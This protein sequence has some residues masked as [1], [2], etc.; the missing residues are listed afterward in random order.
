MLT[1][2][3]FAMENKY[4]AIRSD[5]LYASQQIHRHA[6]MCVPLVV[7]HK[8]RQDRSLYILSFIPH[9]LPIG[10]HLSFSKVFST[11]SPPF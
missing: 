7:T 3:A 9:A 6:C 10:I 11:V 5:I 8:E 4:K 1:E 2:N